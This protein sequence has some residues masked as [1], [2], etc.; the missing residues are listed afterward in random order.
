MIFQ[1]SERLKE[2]IEGKGWQLYD[3]TQPEGR[4]TALSWEEI[5]TRGPA[6][7]FEAGHNY[8]LA[9]VQKNGQTL[10]EAYA[11]T[12]GL[13]PS[14]L[15]ENPDDERWAGL[16]LHKKYLNER[17]QVLFTRLGFQEKMTAA[18]TPETRDIPDPDM[19]IIHNSHLIDTFEKYFRIVRPEEFGLQTPV[20]MPF[21][22]EDN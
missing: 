19:I 16:Y 5:G 22:P 21:H 18:L 13:G 6:Q 20:P 10:R 11:R 15:V 2:I 8:I 4:D 14:L 17:K 7:R 3:S 1:D 12:K 9:P